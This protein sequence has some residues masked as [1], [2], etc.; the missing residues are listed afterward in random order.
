M[1]D[2]ETP[3]WY[4]FNTEGTYDMSNINIQWNEHL[5]NQPVPKYPILRYESLYNEFQLF[6]TLSGG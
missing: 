3:K 4:D 5:L 1:E 2:T 6:R